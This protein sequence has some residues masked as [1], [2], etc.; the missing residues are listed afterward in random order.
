MNEREGG[1]L[2]LDI[3]QTVVLHR[4]Q[5]CEVLLFASWPL[6]MDHLEGDVCRFVVRNSETTTKEYSLNCHNTYWLHIRVICAAFLKSWT[7]SY[8]SFPFSPYLILE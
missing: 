4:S 1:H 5:R 7:I 6:F 3:H 8:A 2:R